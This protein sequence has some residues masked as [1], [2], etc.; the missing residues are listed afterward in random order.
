MS[1]IYGVLL[2]L[3][4]LPLFIISLLLLK[5][6]E[7]RLPPSFNAVFT[8][9]VGFFLASFPND[10]WLFCYVFVLYFCTSEL[11]K[12]LNNSTDT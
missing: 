6:I 10:D 9:Y 1:V 2:L 3:I 12:K 8:F 11:D 5:V 7:V 4:P